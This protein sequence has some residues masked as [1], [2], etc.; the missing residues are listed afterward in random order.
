MFVM[1]VA[2]LTMADWQ[3]RDCS[4]L[5]LHPGQHPTSVLIAA[6]RHNTTDLQLLQVHRTLSKPQSAP[7]ATPRTL[8]KQY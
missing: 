3:Q 1:P 8:T 2:H 4:N 5:L 6:A 7:A